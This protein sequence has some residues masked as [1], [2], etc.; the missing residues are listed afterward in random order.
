MMIGTPT[1][2]QSERPADAAEVHMS[3]G[4]MELISNA[5][6]KNDERSSEM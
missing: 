6:S 1:V 5:A 4:K 2:Q 3:M